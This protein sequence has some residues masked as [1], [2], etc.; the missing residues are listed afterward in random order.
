MT[1][2]GKHDAELSSD[3]S[4]DTTKKKK[5]KLTNTMDEEGDKSDDETIPQDEALEDMDNNEQAIKKTMVSWTSPGYKHY[6]SLPAIKIEDGLVKYIFTCK[7]HGITHTHAKKDTSTTSTTNL[8]NHTEHCDMK[9]NSSQSKQLKIDEVLSQY[10][11][12][13]DPGLQ[14]I[15][16]LLNPQV[17]I[18]SDKTLGYNIK[19]VFEVSKKQLKEILREHERFWCHKGWIEVL[20]LDLIEYIFCCMLN[21]MHTGSYLTE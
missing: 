17:Q 10:T 18:H 1:Q 11:I 8:K 4:T 7:W 9:A 14:K 12:I 19:E 16:C 5:K 3:E 20:T 13:K 2:E 21:K 6:H 15:Y